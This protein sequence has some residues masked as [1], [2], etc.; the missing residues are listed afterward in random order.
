MSANEHFVVVGG[1]GGGGGVETVV[2]LLQTTQISQTF[3]LCCHVAY[4]R[5][6]KTRIVRIDTELFFF[7]SSFFFFLFLP[8]TDTSLVYVGAWTLGCFHILISTQTFQ[9]ALTAL[10]DSCAERNLA[11]FGGRCRKAMFGVW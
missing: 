8:G 3:V 10:V 7:S 2:S 4:A 9:R 5:S 11:E 6:N 1:G